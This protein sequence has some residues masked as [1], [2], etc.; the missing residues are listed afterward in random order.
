MTK[1]DLYEILGGP[2]SAT[3]K[4][5]RA[6][7]RDLARK[8]HP[9]RN[10]DDSAAE[11]R[12]KEASY[13]SQILQ[14]AE[15][16]KLYDEFGETGLRDGFDPDSYRAYTRGPAPGASGG[17]TGSLED[18]LGQMGMGGRGGRSAAGGGGFAHGIGDLFGGAQA[19]SPF[20]RP[21]PREVV[22]DITIDFVNAV[23]GLET[24]L[25]FAMPGEEG[26]TLKVR[27]PAGV[28]DGG[29]I[30]LRGQAPG[31]ADIVLRVHVE[32]HP[33]FDRDGDDL[34]LTL[35][36]TLGEA[37][38]GAKVEVPTPGGEVSLTIPEGVANGAKLR[39]RGKGVQRG[40]RAGDLIVQLQIVL[41][42]LRSDASRDAVDTLETGYSESVRE[43]VSF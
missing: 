7:Y 19:D 4:E 40:K 22:S 39:L 27:I 14:N 24:E 2:R 17:F 6:A 37:Y 20:G 8:Y 11:E 23:R 15:K 18:L 43:G 36:I 12:F 33:H 30:R 42:G 1:R 31:G 28:S 26:R 29:K 38:H 10:P 32:D 5:I 13:A 16:R 21:R 9:D 3:D 41:P 35:P 34:R 25:S